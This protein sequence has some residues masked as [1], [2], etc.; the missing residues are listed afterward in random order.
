MQPHRLLVVV[1]LAT[2]PPGCSKVASTLIR[3]AAP[4]SLPAAA[5]L[6]NKEL[7]RQAV[8]QPS[9]KIGSTRHH[10]ARKVGNF[11]L[12]QAAMEAVNPTRYMDF[13]QT[14]EQW[15]QDL[16]QPPQSRPPDISWMLAGAGRR[17]STK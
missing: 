11:L 8:T 12:E 2:V 3:K 10:P 16:L 13:T 5:P 17:P 1:L 15:Q 6:C 7:A 14:W 9:Q 4:R